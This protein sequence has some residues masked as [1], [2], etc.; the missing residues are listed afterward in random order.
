MFLVVLRVVLLFALLFAIYAG[1]AF[2]MRWDRRKTLEA[3]HAAGA[4]TALTTED[5]VAKGL[6][7]Y[8]RSW[9]RKLLYGV[10]LLP[11][12]VALALYILTGLN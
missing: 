9:E 10:F 12:V 3:E 2:Y 5:Y 11:V 8:E 6:A 1:L 4:T 7:E